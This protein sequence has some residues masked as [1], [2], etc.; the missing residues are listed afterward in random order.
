MILCRTLKYGTEQAEE[1]VTLLRKQLLELWQREHY[2]HSEI[3]ACYQDDY[4]SQRA[5]WSKTLPKFNVSLS[6]SILSLRGK[7]LVRTFKLYRPGVDVWMFGNVLRWR[8][9]QA[10]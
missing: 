7:G 6:R 5:E 4:Q 10:H 8:S 9:S 3:W 1:G 2:P